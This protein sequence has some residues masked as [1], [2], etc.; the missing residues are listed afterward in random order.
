[1]VAPDQRFRMAAD[2]MKVSENE[3]TLLA[4][5]NSLEVYTAAVRAT[6]LWS[7]VRRHWAMVLGTRRKTV[8]DTAATMEKK[9]VCV[10]DKEG[11]VRLTLSDARVVLTHAA[12]A[13]ATLRSLLEIEKVSKG[14]REQGIEEQRGKRAEEGAPG[15]WG[16]AAKT[17]SSPS[18]PVA[19]S[20][21]RSTAPPLPGSP[22]TPP[23]GF[24]SRLPRLFLV[25]GAWV[26]DL[27]GLQRVEQ[28]MALA[29]T[30]MAGHDEN[31][32]VVVVAEF[33]P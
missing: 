3:V 23:A 27:C 7:L 5:T 16:D 10:C 33:E 28:V 31:S 9:R 19:Q 1:M 18:R 8:D 22:V 17:K 12:A 2:T 24:P 14:A 30:E 11:V 6:D 20:P 25:H 29:E 21:R 15:R 13:P 4:E 26:S 32:V